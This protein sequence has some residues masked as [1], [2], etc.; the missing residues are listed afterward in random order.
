LGVPFAVEHHKYGRLERH[1]FDPS[2]FVCEGLANELGTKWVEIGA[3]NLH[4]ARTLAPAL[5]SLLTS[6]DAQPRDVNHSPAA[7]LRDLRLRH[8][9]E[10]ERQLLERHQQA[11]SDTQYRYSVYV[12]ALLRRIDADSPQSLHPEVVARLEYD[13]R[14]SHVRNPP[15]VEF[16]SRE[17]RRFRSAAHRRV[18][19]ALQE[20]SPR[21]PRKDDLIALH[22]LLSQ[23]TGEPP[24][25]LRQVAVADVHATEKA[26]SEGATRR[27]G[28]AERLTWLA[29]NDLVEEFAVRYVKGRAGGETKTEVYTRQQ[30]AVHRTLRSLLVLT[31]PLRDEAS[32]DSLWQ[33]RRLDG[34]VTQPLWLNPAWALE[35]WAFVHGVEVEGPV[36]WNRFRKGV[37]G[38][39]ALRQGGA[40]LRGQKRHTARTFL[41]HYAGSGVLRN[42]AGKVLLETIEQY[43]DEAAAGPLVVTDEAAALLASG[44]EAPELTR[45]EVD[46]LLQGRLDGPHAACR[47]PLD[48]PFADAGDT[49]Q[50]SATGLCFGCGNALITRVHLPAVLLVR[51]VSD[52]NRAADTQ[53]WMQH[54]KHVHDVIEHVILPAFPDD[55]VDDG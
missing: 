36:W 11:G 10:W 16:S 8:L 21:G 35:Q 47:D 2:Q 42:E 19:A 18:Y 15:L 39:E 25:V 20:V 31:G 13:T 1:Y 27:M 33:W 45:A 3:E 46:D 12:L 55:A 38:R 48:S 52:P 22:V 9:D 49:C 53:Q 23:A 32:D 7:G 29:E 34:A 4:A 24:E 14:L 44:E 37:I 30:R 43:F 54:W 26:G 28:P 40:Y 51:E 5:R 17:T 50:M 41:S 6:I